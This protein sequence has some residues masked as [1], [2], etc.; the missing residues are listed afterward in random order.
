MILARKQ[1]TACIH[2]PFLNIFFTMNM[3]CVS[4][5]IH[6]FAELKLSFKGMEFSR[7]LSTR[8]CMELENI[9]NFS[10]G[11]NLALRRAVLRSFVT[12]RRVL[13]LHVRVGN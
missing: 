13:S 12:D 6:S 4:V 9:S 2:R 8:D 5:F 1:Q 10:I 3:S 7:S 11:L